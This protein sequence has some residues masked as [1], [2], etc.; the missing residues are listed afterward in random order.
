MRRTRGAKTHSPALGE[1]RSAAHCAWSQPRQDVH[2]MAT[3]WPYRLSTVCR[4]SRAW[5]LSEIG[6]FFRDASC[7]IPLRV[8]ATIEEDAPTEKTP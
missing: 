7:S 2:S 5:F 3:V 1:A 6:G 8:L 4:L